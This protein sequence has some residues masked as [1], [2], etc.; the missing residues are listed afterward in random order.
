MSHNF[1][2]QTIIKSH[3]IL[4]RNIKRICSTAPSVRMFGLKF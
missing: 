3:G 4:N 1:K 2:I